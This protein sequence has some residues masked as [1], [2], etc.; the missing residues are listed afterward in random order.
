MGGSGHDN[1]QSVCDSEAAK[2]RA[3]EE[4]ENTKKQEELE[5]ENRKT[6][7][8]EIAATSEPQASG[9]ATAKISL[10]LSSGERLQR[11]FLSEQRLDEVYE[12]AHCCRPSANPLH[13]ELCTTF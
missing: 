1:T 11:T 6:R 9:N 2:A 10:R 13:F 4:L 3:A 12:W 8:A 5:E 7:G